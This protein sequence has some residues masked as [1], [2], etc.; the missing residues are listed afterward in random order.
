MARPTPS[1][2]ALPWL[3]VGALLV[4]SALVAWFLR[5]D[6]AASASP[7]R[8]QAPSAPRAESPLPGAGDAHPIPQRAS[9]ESEVEPAEALQ[10]VPVPSPAV[11]VADL[12]ARDQMAVR[13]VDQRDVPIFDAMVTISGLRKEGDEGSWYSRRDEATAVRTERDGRAIVPYERWTDIDAKTVRVDLHVEHS[14]FIPFHDTSF[15]L[16]PGERVLRLEQGSIVWLTAWHGARDQVVPDVSI[17]VEWQ[18]QLG[19][20]GW[21]REAN[22]SWSTAQL[23]PGPH[24]ITLTHTSAELGSL[25]SDFTPFEVVQFGRVDL[26]LELEPLVTLRGRL[27]ERVPRPVVDGHV[28]LNL[29]VSEGQLGLSSDHEVSV[30]ADGTFEIPG[31]RSAAGQ[32]IA[33]CDGWCSKLVP[34]RTLEQSHRR[35]SPDATPEERAQ[36]LALAQAEERIAQPAEAGQDELLVIEME[37]AGELE[38]LVTD[39]SGTALQDVHVS[40]WPN[41]H[42]IGV[43]STIVPWRSWSAATD[44]RGLARITNLPVDPSLWFGAQS[45]THQ[46]RKEDRDSNPSVS[47]E[48]GQ[49]ARYELI[50]EKIP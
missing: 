44:A 33:L 24:W 42:W 45:A 8:M 34:P 35:L 13:V 31:L 12:A 6:R 1:R 10:D 38:V 32:V 17:A 19:Q 28:W 48:S 9:V 46:L 22:G 11:E 16:A 23:A 26:E 5:S 7:P 27:D 37:R 3:L 20:D 39:E 50:L 4:V 15:V 49:T 41:V 29:H 2:S 18:A 30:A 36:A 25:A 47:I 14:D 43:G 21:R 40:A